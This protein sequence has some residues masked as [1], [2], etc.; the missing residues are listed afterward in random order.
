MSNSTAKPMRSLLGL[1][2]EKELGESLPAIHLVR[3]TWYVRWVGKF[4]L[5]VLMFF[6]VAMIFVPWQQNVR[7]YGRIY[8]FN[9]Q[10]RPQIVKSRQ[11]GIIKSVR[12][13]LREGTYVSKGELI[14]EIEPFAPEAVEQIQSQIAQLQGGKR[15][16]EGS[17]VLAEQNIELQ[18]LSG[19]SMIASIKKEVEAAQQKYQQQENELKVLEAEF[20]QKTYEKNQAETLYPKGLISEQ[21]LV[22]KRNA[23]N[24]AFSKLDK[25]KAQVIEFLA[26][27]IGK[28]KELESKSHDLYIKNRQAEQKAQ[29]ETQKLAKI[30][31]DLTDLEMKKGELGRL[32]IRS[33]VDGFLSEVHGIEGA[34]TV[35]KG[36]DLFTVVPQAQD[37]AV[38]LSVA[39]RDMPLVH[40]GDKVRLQFQ[41]WPAVQ[42]VGWPSVA[43]G[44]FGGQVAAISPTDN[45][46]GDFSVLVVPDPKEPQWPDNRYLRQ[47]VRASGWILL[48]QVALGYEI[49]RQ[50][51]GFPPVISE[52]EP[53]K[54]KADGFD[55]EKAG[56]IKLP[57][58]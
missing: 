21:E 3:T 34:N 19:E 30:E 28:E 46:K 58:T 45:S 12:R 35:K 38:E 39:G 24:Q 51:N 31:K 33:P 32:D 56:K 20:E 54:A 15:A 42:F 8:A 43:V 7:G 1:R 48:K 25:G 57:K 41:G 17:L 2:P 37:L 55:G 52:D 27:Y 44:T 36:D 22:A 16:S 18:R 47:G 29:E 40:V 4:T 49:W 6:I 26:T 53:S 10:E 14:M 23:Y 50:M 9:P 13:D 5:V 11:D